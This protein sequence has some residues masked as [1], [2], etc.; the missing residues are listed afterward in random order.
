MYFY[1]VDY[2]AHKYVIV[3]MRNV[4]SLYI[5]KEREDTASS[6]SDVESEAPGCKHF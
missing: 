1:D 3:Y 2:G 6:D 4:L 5:K